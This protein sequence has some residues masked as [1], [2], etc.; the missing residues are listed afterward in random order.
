[1]FMRKWFY[2]LFV[3]L[4]CLASTALILCCTAQY[5]VGVTPDS[6]AY[7]SAARNLAM[8]NGLKIYDKSPYISWPPLY[9]LLLAGLEFIK[10]D[11]FDG[12][13]LINVVC[14]ILSVIISW[15][16]LIPMLKY[17]FLAI[18]CLVMIVLSRPLIFVSLFAYSEPIF[19]VLTLLSLYFLSKYLETGGWS[20]LVSATIFTMLAIQCR[21][22]GC[23]ILFTGCVIIYFA[24]I[25][26]K[27]NKIREWLFFLFATIIPLLAW[28]VRN[29]FV[30]GSL[31]G[32][33]PMPRY[34]LWQQPVFVL[35]TITL[36]FLPSFITVWL[37]VSLFVSILAILIFIVCKK[38]S[39]PCGEIKV[40]YLF[41]LIFTIF[42]V[43]S[44]SAGHF[45]RPDARIL[46]PIYIPLVISV[47]YLIDRAVSTINSGLKRRW[48]ISTVVVIMALMIGYQMI[49]RNWLNV[50][51]S[52]K[53]GVGG[54]S[55]EEFSNNKLLVSIKRAPISGL[56]FSN[57]PDAI[58]FLTGMT[59]F[60]NPLKK[61]NKKEILKGIYEKVGRRRIFFIELSNII[62][63]PAVSTIADLKEV[64]PL[65]QIA[66]D[67]F[68]SI[69]EVTM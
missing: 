41:T 8:G 59:A 43:Y 60:L 55:T 11:S 46:S 68:V 13:R 39:N 65:E 42:I 52:C 64:M 67:D 20:S 17:K 29:Y 25:K 58:Y 51:N 31:T 12:A 16:Y 3:I 61:N 50:L 9:P 26:D 5:G 7:I 1:M 21:Y 49:Y 36:W 40:F 69:Y 35:D 45:P 63:H 47:I 56:V 38:N 6:V 44:S 66:K 37:R 32:W 10:V 57:A 53:H 24:Y 15:F 34:F 18:I 48:V 33:R 2:F 30:A 4:L 22:V 27:K 19:I 14:I 54:Y 62:T 28:L 23:T